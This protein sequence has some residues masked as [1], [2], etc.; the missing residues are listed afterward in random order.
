MLR[1]ELNARDC[2]NAT[3]LGARLISIWTGLALTADF[4]VDCEKYWSQEIFY[5]YPD[6]RELGK[7]GGR[8]NKRLAP[9][10]PL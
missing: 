9:Q 3:R 1:K 2:V 10:A 6:L 7:L 4:L 5:I 8:I